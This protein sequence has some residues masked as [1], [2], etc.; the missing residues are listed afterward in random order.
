MYLE[1]ITYISLGSFPVHPKYSNPIILAKLI[2]ANSSGEGPVYSVI[3]LTTMEGPVYLDYNN[4]LWFKSIGS[5]L[6]SIFLL[7]FYYT[8]S[9]KTVWQRESNKKTWNTF[10]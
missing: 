6:F 9:I 2:N 4:W 10:S 8:F 5:S 1:N 7:S 3:A